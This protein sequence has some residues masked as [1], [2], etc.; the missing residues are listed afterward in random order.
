[1]LR[2]I[3]EKLVLKNC[4]FLK[5]IFFKIFL[6]QKVTFFSPFFLFFN[7]NILNKLYRFSTIFYFSTNTSL[8]LFIKGRVKWN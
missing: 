2:E 5:L 1:M 7:I 8:L 3:V 6:T 4:V